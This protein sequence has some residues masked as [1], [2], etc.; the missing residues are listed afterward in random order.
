ML[1]Q[2]ALAHRLGE[3]QLLIEQDIRRHDM[4]DEVLD[5]LDAD[6]VEHPLPLLGVG[7]ADLADAE[8]SCIHESI[9]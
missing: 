3:V 2:L 6:G 8:V 5:A 9:V 1:D 4:V 7:D